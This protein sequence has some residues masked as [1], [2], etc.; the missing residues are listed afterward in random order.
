M[1]EFWGWGSHPSPS[2]GPSPGT[3]NAG[4]L[5]RCATGDLRCRPP[6]VTRRQCQSAGRKA[7]VGGGAA[8]PGLGSRP[9]GS[10]GPT[11]QGTHPPGG[12][13]G[14]GHLLANE[15]AQGDV[16]QG[17]HAPAH[18]LCPV[19]LQPRPGKQVSCSGQGPHGQL[20]HRLAS[21]RS[22]RDRNDGF[23]AWRCLTICV[24]RGGDTHSTATPPHPPRQ[25]R[26][27]S[28]FQA[29]RSRGSQKPA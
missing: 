11:P 17:P 16:L 27:H 4:P 6:Q 19:E 14:R 21:G 20:A 24:Q 10:G 2:S 28:V 12:G 7:Q 23:C 15:G 9:E 29:L 26:A 13:G 18:V 1:L 8:G 5:T 22:E 3:D 25:G